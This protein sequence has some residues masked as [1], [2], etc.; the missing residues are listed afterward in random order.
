MSVNKSREPLLYI[1]QP[2]I[3]FPKA[4]MQHTYVVRKAEL[5]SENTVLEP[6]A[7]NESKPNKTLESNHHNHTHEH[8]VQSNAEETKEKSLFN[9]VEDVGEPQAKRQKEEIP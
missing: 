6:L 4:E 9:T 8:P 2:E 7:E 1:Q 3:S 5:E